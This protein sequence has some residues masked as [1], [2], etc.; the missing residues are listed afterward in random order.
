MGIAHGKANVHPNREAKLSWHMFELS[1]RLVVER[2]R[3]DTRPD[4]LPEVFLAKVVQG[5][6][7]HDSQPSNLTSSNPAT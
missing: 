5:L 6:V 3:A 2:D 4:R 1:G 7:A